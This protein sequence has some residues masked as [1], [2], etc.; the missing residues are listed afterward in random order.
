MG[1]MKPGSHLLLAAALVLGLALSSGTTQAQPQ[2]NLH[3]SPMTIYLAK[4]GAD[5]CGKDCIETPSTDPT[6]APYVIKLSSLGWSDAVGKLRQK[7]A[8]R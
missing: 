1:A 4:G 8:G 2:D 7:C 5:A 3:D 6:A